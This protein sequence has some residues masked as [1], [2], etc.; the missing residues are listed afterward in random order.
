MHLLLE[1]CTGTISFFF[2]FF[3]FLLP[4]A[5]VIGCILMRPLGHLLHWAGFAYRNAPFF[6]AVGVSFFCCGHKTLNEMYVLDASSRSVLVYEYLCFVTTIS[7]ILRLIVF[8]FK[9]FAKVNF[10]TSSDQ[11]EIAGGLGSS[12][13]SSNSPTKSAARRNAPANAEAG[14]ISMEE[15]AALSKLPS[16]NVDYS[17]KAILGCEVREDVCQ[18]VSRLVPRFDHT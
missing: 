10:A 7:T 12:V 11:G 17:L 16:G 6:C 4:C 8:L 14:T 13:G 3:F 15:A 18:V 1:R 9:E 2:F 5:C